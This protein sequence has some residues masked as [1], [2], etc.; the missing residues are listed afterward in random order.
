MNR[1]KP[2]TAKNAKAPK[3]TTA[4]KATKATKN[5][6][7]KAPTK[8]RQPTTVRR[9]AKKPA[10]E[11]PLAL[12]PEGAP[13]PDVAAEPEAPLVLEPALAEPPELGVL[14]STP[15]TIFAE[16][17]APPELD[18]PFPASRRAIFFDVENTS[19]AQH[20]ARVI[21]HLQIDRRGQRTDFVAV[22]NWRVIG[23]DTARL[24]AHHGAHLVHSA[25]S[26]GVRDWSDLRIAVGA[27]AWLAGARPGDVIEIVSD[28]RAFD[29]VG[30]V[31]SSLG[32]TFRRLSYRGLAGA[33]AEEIARA[34]VEPAVSEGRSSSSSSSSDGRGNRYRGRY[35][36]RRDARPAPP[37]RSTPAPV[38]AAPPP[39]AV[40]PVE[41]GPPE[42]EPHTAPHDEIVGV[43]RDLMRANPGRGV[44]IDAV[45]NALKARGFSRPPGS[46]RL[47]T[48][49]R[50]LKEL[51]IN[52][53]GIITL[54]GSTP[55]GA[56]PGDSP[57]SDSPP[58]DL[59]PSVERTEPP[60]AVVT[61][62]PVVVQVEDEGPEPGNEKKTVEVEKEG[63]EIGNE[64]IDSRPP[65]AADAN[66]QRRRR[67]GGR[68][69]HGRGRPQPS[70]TP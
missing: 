35:R 45:A 15:E 34:P 56:A 43:V 67:R 49:L 7:K 6:K 8:S 64:R 37:P 48:R 60:P 2:M 10:L 57:P 18:R 51:E 23:H 53:A 66:A 33:P 1:R 55:A 36:G 69:W 50:R 25:P 24:L 68:R 20:I 12:V 39:P 3:A 9:R 44:S 5:A 58:S 41:A 61:I 62:A 38:A 22:G 13:A 17:V 11:K 42:A 32:I 40:A 46:P 26:V 16:R 63:P 28:D 31:A 14:L 47:I 65:A 21:E 4:T 27:G 70:A 29:A 52:R 54:V 19:R 30:D 59:A